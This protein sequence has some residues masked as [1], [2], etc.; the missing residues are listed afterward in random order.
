MKKVIA[1]ACLSMLPLSYAAAEGYQVNA[2]STK[3]AGMGHVG[4]AMKLGAESMHFNPAGLVFMENRIHLSAGVSGVFSKGKFTDG[5]YVQ[6]PDNTPSTP[7]YV[8]AG[9][10]IYDNLA[11]GISLTT[12]YGSSMNWGKDWKGA[13]LIQDISLKA[14]NIQPTV[15]WKIMDRLSIGAGLMMEF[16]NIELSR[17]LIG[18]G[19]MSGMA[20]GLMDQ[21]G[22]LLQAHPELGA[23]AKPVIDKLIA[24]MAKYDDASAA[25]VN[26]KGDAGVRLGF[27]VGAMYDINDKVTVGVSYRS[28]VKARVKEGDIALSYANETDLKENIFK[29]VETLI[30]TAESFGV[31][32]PVNLQIP[33]LDQGTFSAELPLPSNWNVGVTYK[34]TNRWILSG[35][36]QFVGWGA[37]K[38]LEINFSPS[39][40]SQY[41]M[42][43]KKEYMNSRI[44]RVGAQFAATN[45]LD[46]RM[47]AYYDESPV[48]D[49][50]LNPETPS[51]NKFGITG[52]LSFRPVDRLSVDFAFSYVTGFGRDGSYTDKALVSGAERK[53]G[54]HYNIYALMPSIGVAYAF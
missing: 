4:T 45:R 40:L 19:E 32:V 34:P 51:M 7:L 46:V 27:N 5:D 18:P 16:G 30:K 22:P 13:H 24:D 3:Q 14:F 17:A 2:Q 33:A 21:F 44:Y 10:K 37:Y 11:A 20:S 23:I 25:S 31:S 47:G 53:F 41:D 38:K 8:Y 36:V 35:E 50:F 15:S 54:G 29:Q 42:V 9:F 26:L 1:L 43:A 39:S 49:D 6:K 28:K 52:G 48:K 12:P